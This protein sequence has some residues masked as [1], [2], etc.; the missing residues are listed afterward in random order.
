[1][2]ID[3]F[4]SINCI[5]NYTFGNDLLNSLFGSTITVALI[6]SFIMILLVMLMYPAKSG[7]SIKIVLK[8]FIYMTIFSTLILF[9]YKSIN[10][11]RWDDEHNDK[12]S[13]DIMRGVNISD[14][15]IVYGVNNLIN[16]K[17]VDE[18]KIKKELEEVGQQLN[19]NI[20]PTKNTDNYY[21]GSII[22]VNNNSNL[23]G[24]KPPSSNKN[25]YV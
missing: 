8:M 12:I 17:I 15:D 24:D 13:S 16:P 21:N 3:L 9:L 18:S 10:K 25:P 1:M 2:P 20:S 7:T 19:V 6:I 4:S 11:Y 23:I 5:S 22:E 14:R